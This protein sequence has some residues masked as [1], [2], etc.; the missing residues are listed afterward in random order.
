MKGVFHEEK[1]ICNHNISDGNNS[2][3][4]VN[5]DIRQE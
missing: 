2:T 3:D 1:A 5:R 4:T